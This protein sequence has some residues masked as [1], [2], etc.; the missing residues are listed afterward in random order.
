MWHEQPA[1]AVLLAEVMEI[2]RPVRNKDWGY[3]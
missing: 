1:D 2:L 3:Y